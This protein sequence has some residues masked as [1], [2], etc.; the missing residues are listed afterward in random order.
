[1]TMLLHLFF[2]LIIIPVHLTLRF[3]CL[4]HLQGQINSLYPNEIQLQS[5]PLYLVSIGR[6]DKKLNPHVGHV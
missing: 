6:L 2:E 3:I 1:M 4:L 5:K